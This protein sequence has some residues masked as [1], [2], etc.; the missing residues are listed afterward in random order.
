[1]SLAAL[2]T[3]NEPVKYEFPAAKSDQPEPI[4]EKKWQNVPGL[5][6]FYLL[7]T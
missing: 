7:C 5:P 2:A 4:L 1:M 3:R 6:Y